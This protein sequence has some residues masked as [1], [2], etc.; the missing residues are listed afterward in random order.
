MFIGHQTRSF[1]NANDDILPQDLNTFYKNCQSFYIESVEQLKSRMPSENP[2][3]NLL[4]ILKPSEREQGSSSVITL[5]EH[6]P[7][8]IPES[9]LDDLHSEWNEYKYVKFP[10]HVTEYRVD[11]Y[12]HEISLL[13]DSNGR[14]RFTLLPKLMKC[15]VCAKKS[16]RTGL[17]SGLDLHSIR[18]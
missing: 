18:I 7:N 10:S 1:I 15:T 9:M 16:L 14:K 4:N 5:A 17:R 11:R 12:W 2:V 6:F 3:I 8:V 13:T